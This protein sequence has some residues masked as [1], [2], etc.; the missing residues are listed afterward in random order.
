VIATSVPDEREWIQWKGRTAR[1]DRP[2]QFYVVL[3]QKG[4][5]FSDKPGLLAKVK[6]ATIG[7]GEKKG[8]PDHDARVE[9]LLDCADDGIGDKLIAYEGEQAA[10]EKLNE[11]A[12]KYYKANPRSFDAPWPNLELESDLK[13]RHFMTSMIDAKPEE[14]KAKAKEVLGLTLD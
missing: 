13:M 8:Q 14:I 1:Q 2:G 5:P 10:G 6:K 12:V 3:D 7:A 11:V 4:K 9:M